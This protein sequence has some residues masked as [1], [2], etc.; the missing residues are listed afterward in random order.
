MKKTILSLLL[1]FPLLVSAQNGCNFFDFR[2]L[3]IERVNLN[4]TQ[5]DF[6]PSFVEDELWFSAFTD[7]EI[8]RLAKG[9]NKDIFYNLYN[10]KTDVEGNV[11]GTKNVQFET[12]SAG[13]HAGPVSYCEKTQELFVTLSNFDNPEISNNV[14]QKAEIRLKIIITKKINGIWTVTE[15]F[16]YNNPLYSV[17]HPAI[18]VT[19]D[20][21]FY[22]SNK[23]DSGYGE[24]DIYMSVRK[25]G[26]WGEPINM[27]EKVNSA[28]DEMFPFFFDG[29]VLFYSTNKAKN[30]KDDFNLMYI[31]K[32][33]DSFGD[34][35]SL[36]EFNTKKDDFGL[37]IHSK[38]KVGYFVSR[39][40]GGMGDDDIYKVTFKGEHNLELVVMDKKTL[41]NIQ[42]PKVKFSD[43]LIGNV[44]GNLL[45]RLLPENSTLLVTS[46]IEGYQNTSINITTVGKPYGIIRDTIWVE[47]VEVGQKFVLENIFYDYDKW[48]ILPESEVELNKLITVLNDNP[49]WKV[50]LG[51][52]TDARGSD[53]YNEILSQKR[54]DSAVDYIIKNGIS[55][56]RII[57][58][59]YGE[60]QLINHCKNGVECPDE[61]HRQNRRTEFK[62]LEMDRK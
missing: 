25:N 1:V 12:I 6:G 31:C 37:I 40:N 11:T 10:V 27:G 49:S 15:E 43:N 60:S 7:D 18:S 3:E 36:D 44:K 53:S 52:H 19:G 55:K 38:G 28:F 54:S 13:F 42:K 14:Y 62:I 29:S 16:P 59:G 61:V 35:K 58:K 30:K 47:K 5:S 48:D 4:T 41:Q 22:A 8:Q 20:T 2:K 45:I 57:A 51:S 50:E 24:S 39:R 9:D 46:E 34:S 56:D 33:D 17:G 32:A 21:L 26:K 23:P